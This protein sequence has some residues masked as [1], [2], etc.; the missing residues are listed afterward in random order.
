MEDSIVTLGVYFE[1]KDSELYGGE[2]TIGYCNTNVDLKISSPLEADISNYVE[3]QCK[4]VADMCRVGVEKVR[5]ISRTEYEENTEDEEDD[6]D[7]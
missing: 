2:G 3:H 4:G 6:S 5:V 7:W 1:V